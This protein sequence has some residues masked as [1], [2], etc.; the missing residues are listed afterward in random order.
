[1]I[2]FLLLVIL[3]YIIY[4]ILSIF[5]AFFFGSMSQ[6]KKYYFRKKP[7]EPPQQPED[8]KKYDDV[9][10]AKFKDMKDDH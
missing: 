3:G 8:L 5:L 1:M 6:K 9:V 7:A 4:R 2:R 10:D